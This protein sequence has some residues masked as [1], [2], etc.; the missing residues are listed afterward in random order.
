MWRY[1]RC[2]D[3][4]ANLDRLARVAVTIAPKPYRETARPAAAIGGDIGVC[5]TRPDQN[6]VCGRPTV[7]L[8][9]DIGH[10]LRTHLF[11]VHTASGNFTMIAGTEG[12]RLAVP[13]QRELAA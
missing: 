12:F 9:G 10:A 13:D 5:R 8:S 2:L 11:G 1:N 6:L 7:S 4:P 3:L